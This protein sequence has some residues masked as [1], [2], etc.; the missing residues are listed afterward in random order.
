MEHDIK[1]DDVTIKKAL[2]AYVSTLFKDGTILEIKKLNFSRSSLKS[3]TVTID[4]D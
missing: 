3:V 4:Q 1:L 2:H